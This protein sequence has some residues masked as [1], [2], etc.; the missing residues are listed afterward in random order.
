[1]LSDTS[2]DIR[3]KA[4]VTLGRIGDAKAIPKLERIAKEDKVLFVRKAAKKALDKIV[5]RSETH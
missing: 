5:E 1:M 3:R 2:P 4:A